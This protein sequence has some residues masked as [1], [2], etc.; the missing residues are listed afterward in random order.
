MVSNPGLPSVALVIHDLKAGGSE[1]VLTFLAQAWHRQGRPVHVI[2]FADECA[3]FFHPGPGVQRIVL[4]LPMGTGGLLNSLRRILRLRRALKKARAPVVISFLPVFNMLT[5][6]AAAGLGL[7][8]VICERNDPARQVLQRP[9]QALRRL[10]YRYA[11]RVTAN[12]RGALRTLSAYVPAHKLFFVPNPVN[13]P[14]AGTA[15][16]ADAREP[17]ILAVGRLHYQKAYDILLD[18]FAGIAAALPE[19]RLVI[20]GTGRLEAPLRMRAE[21]LGLHARIAWYGTIPDLYPFYRRAS[22]FAQPSRYEGTPN[23]LLEAL[24]CGLPAVVSDASPGPLEYVEHEVSGLVVP[25][26]NAGA[27]SAA[28]QRLAGDEQL[29][30]RLG[31]EARKRVAGLSATAVLAI[32]EQVLETPRQQGRIG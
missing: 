20:I 17:I 6:L 28:L 19:W 9:W 2:T 10:L 24:S 15:Q 25:V 22:I 18:A 23:A 3:D 12:S 5:I 13:G 8:V 32:W 31:E 27:L 29:R 1:K 11:D 26:D 30:R 7:R 4:G 14:P 21:Q 16:D